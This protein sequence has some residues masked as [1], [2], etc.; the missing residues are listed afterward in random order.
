MEYY[1]FSIYGNR[2]AGYFC[3]N[4]NQLIKFLLYIFV[5]LAFISC[6]KDKV[7]TIVL[8]GDRYVSLGLGYEWIYQM[9]SIVFY[10]DEILSPDTF[11][12]LVRYVV[13]DSTTI[14]D[15][16]EVYT[17]EQ[18]SKHSESTSW[19]FQRRFVEILDTIT[20]LR[21]MEDQKEIVLSFPFGEFKEWDS[22]IY[23]TE[24]PSTSYYEKIDAL[25]TINNQ[26]YDSSMTVVR[27]YNIFFTR[28]EFEREKYA[29]DIGL[30]YK[31][32]ENLSRLEKANINE[33][34]GSK[35]KL[36]LLDYEK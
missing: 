21:T 17:I 10:G 8:E 23:N 26:L 22:N 4:I 28:S 13:I 14:N 6:R 5:L 25:D 34:Y 33:H 3:L 2:G 11:H 16:Q 31:E 9:D 19:K 30:I 35:Y 27:E 32:V 12:Y 15:N 1:C 18:S 7:K 29:K 36:A 20:L 24:D